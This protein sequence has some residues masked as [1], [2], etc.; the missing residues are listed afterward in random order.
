MYQNG[1]SSPNSPSNFKLNVPIIPQY[2]TRSIFRKAEA[3]VL[4]EELGD[5]AGHQYAQDYKSAF[6]RKRQ[7]KSLPG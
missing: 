4:A 5:G 7:Q 2:V 6:N 3:P 1:R